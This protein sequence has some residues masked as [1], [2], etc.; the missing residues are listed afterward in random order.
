MGEWREHPLKSFVD[1]ARSICYGIVQPGSPVADGVPILRVNNFTGTGL[2]VSSAMRVSTGIEDNYRRSRLQGG[3]LLVTLV[4]SLGLTAIAPPEMQGWNVARA[5]GVIPLSPDAD[6]RWINFVVRSRPAQEFMAMRANTTVQATFNLKDLAELPIP[7]PPEELRVPMSELLSALDDKIELNRR[8]NETLE[9]S[10]RALFRDWFVDFGPTRAKQAGAAPYLSPDLWSLF[11]ARLDDEGKPEGWEWGTLGDVAG[12][13]NAKVEPNQIDP[14]TPYIGLEHMPRQSIA[15]GEWEGAG[16][17]SSA[18][19]SFKAG[20]ILFGKLRPYFHKVG[21]APVDGI[22]STDI[23][24]I[25]AKQPYNAA[26]VLACVSTE[27][28][29]A[30]T[31]K[32]S[33]GTKMPRT[34]WT[35]MGGY[36]LVKPQ[37]QLAEK[38]ETV[39]GAMYEKIITNIHESRTLAQTR[40]ML[41]PKLMSGEIRVRGAGTLLEAA[42]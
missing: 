19:S 42:L 27:D 25:Q 21:I 6:I 1:P 28:F 13:V 11:P 15:L 33:T 17:V 41:L 37:R 36:Q 3:E 20:Q 40:D 31:D 29:V 5:V 10:A 34:S 14:D 16:K 39:V 12:S 26:L 9:A 24:V 18:K 38:F 8:M 4:G 2:D 23:V 35:I 7:M 32:G 30:F 22:C